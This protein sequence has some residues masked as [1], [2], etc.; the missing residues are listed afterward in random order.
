VRPLG[1]A[2]G[3]YLTLYPYGESP[4]TASTINYKSDT[5]AVA[6]GVLVPLCDPAA[7]DCDHDLN[8]YNCTSLAVH[9]AVD[10]AGYLT[11]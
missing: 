1:S 4:P 9:L 6:N 8:V 3:G 5:T 2:S 10:V 7:A 11:E